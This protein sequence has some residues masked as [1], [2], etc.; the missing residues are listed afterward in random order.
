MFFLEDKADFNIE[1]ETLQSLE[2]RLSVIE[3]QE[4]FSNKK[5][6]VEKK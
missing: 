6:E 4:V 5:K 1:E 3:V 2:E